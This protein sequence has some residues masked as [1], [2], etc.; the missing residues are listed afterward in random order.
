MLFGEWCFAAHSIHYSRLPDWFL[1]FD[2]YD[3]KAARFWS[4]QRRDILVKEV[5]LNSAPLIFHGLTDIQEATKLLGPSKLTDG[6]AEGIYLRWDEGGFLG[7]RAKLV[8]PEFSQAIEQH[9]SVRRLRTNSLTSPQPYSNDA[10]L[11]GR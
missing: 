8:R 5:G 1:A 6:P 11:D 3:V 7:Q 10:P 2:V 4:V 9:W